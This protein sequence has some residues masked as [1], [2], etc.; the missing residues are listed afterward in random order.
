MA[1]SVYDEPGNENSEADPTAFRGVE[2]EPEP[3]IDPTR[4]KFRPGRNQSLGDNASRRNRGQSSEGGLDRPALRNAEKSGDGGTGSSGGAKSVSPGGLASSERSGSGGGGLSSLF[5]PNDKGGRFQQLKAKAKGISKK[6]W[7]RVTAMGGGVVVILIILFILIIGSLK[8][9]NVMQHITGYEFA[10]VTRQFSQSAQRATDEALAVEATND[11]TYAALKDKYQG[12]RDNTWGKLDKYRPN[13]VIENLGENSGL[14]LKYKTSRL[15]GRQI[16]VGGSI[17]GQEFKI[18]QA[19]GISRWTPGLKQ[20]VEFRNRQA[21]Y[22]S[23]FFQR[24]S[25]AMKTNDVGPLVRGRVFKTLLNDTGGSLRGYALSKFKSTDP[26]VNK[27]E[28]SLD[29]YKATE[30][31]RTAPDNAKTAQ[32]SEAD[33]ATADAVEQDSQDPKKVQ[34]IVANNGDDVAAEAAA[35]AKLNPS[36]GT[37]ALSI[38][39]PIY[40]VA[41][42]ICII[43][44]GSVERAQP[45][46]DNQ[47]K[48]QQNAYNNLAARADEQKAGGPPDGS[49]DAG[50]LATAIGATNDQIGDISQSNPE[51]RAAGG[52]VDTSTIPSA[53][54]GAG[55][56]FDF[57]IFNALGVPQNSP[58]GI[59]INWALGNA[60]PVLTNLYVAGGIGV[61]NIVAGIVSLGSSQAAE[62]AA[63]QA[64]STAVTR[65]VNR[66][67]ANAVARLTAKVV[68]KNGVKTVERGFLNRAMRFTFQQGLIIGG[69]V[70]ATEL[71]HL[72][73]AARSGVVNNG[74]AQNQDLV[75]AAD[76]GAN[77]RGGELSRQQQFGR[78]LGKGEVAESDQ[79]DR[80]TLASQN[81]QRSFTERYFAFSNADSLVSHMGL[82]L[83]HAFHGGVLTSVGSLGSSFFHPMSSIA[84][85]AGLIDGSVK[86]SPDPSTQHYGNVQ[87]GWTQEEENLIDSSDSYKP[88]EN[89]AILDASG[90]EAAIAQKYAKCFGYSSDD[91]GNLTPNLQGDG[92]LGSLLSKAEIARDSEGNVTNDG[93]CSPSQLGPGNNDYGHHMVFR[94][95]LAHRFNHTIDQLTDEQEITETPVSGASPGVAP[96]GDAQQLAQQIL[97]ASKEGK[98]NFDHEWDAYGDAADG[99]AP[100]QNIQETA[101]GEPAKTTSSCA[102]RG[103]QPPNSTVNLDPKLLRF[104]LELSQQEHFTINALAGE[105]HGSSGSYHY[106][107]QAVD[108]G[109]PFDPGPAN[110]I[111]SKYGISDGTGETCGNA[112]H[113][114]YS[115]GGH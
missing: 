23:G 26:V 88:L 22:Q 42:P 113:Y 98:I 13:K 79:L 41:A 27:A 72:V 106:Q 19:E 44:D 105:C 46:I 8:L 54:A 99:S 115:I 70:G 85:V 52:N 61:A 6:G 12:L 60:C 28:A 9:P 24:A 7:F 1:D 81:R 20:V 82:S 39:N 107:G 25:E 78:P 86:A 73:V 87:F 67:V 37:Q 58:E 21:F 76:S 35:N 80:A 108:F 40:A 49:A 71:A 69:T 29:T 59:F 43:Y 34:E 55:G 30:A 93:L 62:E 4:L 15:T 102:G 11:G 97:E 64:A 50:E 2:R 31:G 95:R 74:F 33:Q 75:N 94:W 32:I 90:Q 77:I 101:R 63:G 14:E 89:R 84:S 91:Q 17:D 10:R 110:S 66:V 111:G 112:G 104:L 100:L 18:N 5:N 47:A 48:Q 96:S 114:H 83:A 45:S 65:Y 103:A 109:C 3:E 36:F 92:S 38:A 68:E 51:I 53:E 57:S 56:S 16:F